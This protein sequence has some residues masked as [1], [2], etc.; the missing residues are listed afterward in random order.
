VPRSAM[1]ARELLRHVFPWEAQVGVERIDD[2]DAP[3]DD[4]PVPGEDLNG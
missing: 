4:H 1:T 3:D 2:A